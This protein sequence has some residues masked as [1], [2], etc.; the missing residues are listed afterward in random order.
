MKKWIWLIGLSLWL[1][2][3]LTVLD[4]G[5]EYFGKSYTDTE[6]FRYEFSRISQGLLFFELDPSEFKVDQS[7]A[8]WEIDQYRADSASLTDQIQMVRDRFAEAITA[9]EE[10][11]DTD[12]AE[13]LTEQRDEEL[14][15]VREEFT[16]DEA[17]KQAV[18]EQREIAHEQALQQLAE[19]QAAF[20]MEASGYTYQ[21]KALGSGETIAKG[22]LVDHPLFEHAFSVQDPLSFSG[23]YWDYDFQMDGFAGPSPNERYSGTIQIPNKTL[24]GNDFLNASSQ[25]QFIKVFLYLLLISA[26]AG[27]VWLYRKRPVD[28]EWYTGAAYAKW[29]KIA[30][31]WK[32]LVLAIT[33][34]FALVG[35]N[36]F[37]SLFTMSRQHRS[38]AYFLEM[39]GAAAIALVFLSLLILQ[40]I[41]L[42]KHF[43]NWQT[44]A[45]ETKQS[46]TWNQLQ[47][48][49]DTFLDRSI[50]FQMAW[51]LVVVFFWGIGT[52]V[53]MIQ[54]VVVI[55]WLPATLFIG[56]PSLLFLMI[57]LGY[58]N[59]LMKGTAQ[60]AQ[61]SIGTELAVK[62]KSPLARHATHLNLLR[63][64]YVQSVSARTKSERLKTELITNVSHDL[65]TPLTS[66]ITYTDLLKNENLGPEERRKYVDILDRK[67]ERLK[68]LIED[69]FEV[70]KMATGNADINKQR[71][72]M[73]QLLAQALAEHEEAIKESRLDVRLAVPDQPLYAS[74][75]GQKWWRLLD[76]LILNATKYSLPH[77]RVYIALSE[78]TGEIVTTIKNVTRFELGD[79][80]EELLERFKRGDTS[81]QTEGSGLGLAIAQSIVDLHGGQLKLEVDGDLFKVT[82]ILSKP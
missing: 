18:V 31:E 4:K 47:A 30:I 48:A 36:R 49:G 62:G 16:D 37:L 64:G 78:H 29:R 35:V 52:A 25:F 65:R 66:I 74:V 8:S 15:A 73:N 44:F 46:F 20:E 67:S 79:N 17:A 2:S 63:E 69:L 13:Q 81:R 5:M 51:V 72:D 26:I 61:G 68:V 77:S 55:V 22:T 19:Q 33:T 34:L 43:G 6:E 27:A 21:L 71:L 41:W 38:A 82:V 70:S 59:R 28:L 45:M 56:L 3:F 7:V 40:L 39:P 14:L 75:D 50:G 9:A 23:G 32:T 12:L 57:R 76:N 60:L 24:A 42:W 53:M 54:P 11:E 80:S 10:N 1:L 58:L